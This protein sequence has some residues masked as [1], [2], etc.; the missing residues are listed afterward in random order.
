MF[1]AYPQPA[2][3]ILPFAVLFLAWLHLGPL[4]K[5]GAARMLGV[6]WLAFLAAAG[7]GLT[8]KDASA[9]T[10]LVSGPGGSIAEP[11]GM[12]AVYGEAVRRIDALTRPGEPI[13][14]APVDTLLYILADRPSPLARISLLPGALPRAA[15]QQNVIASIKRAGVRLIVTNRLDFPEY[16]HTHFG[17]SFDSVLAAWIR[18][19]YSHASTIDAPGAPTLDLWLRRGS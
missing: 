18:A 8:L 4:A 12:A 10:V 7:V 13:V 5:P 6:V 9:K 19:N 16:G 3:W 2:I 17:G 15:D 1:A 11:P 14:A